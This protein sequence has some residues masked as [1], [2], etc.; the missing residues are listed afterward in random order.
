M[1]SVSP[2]SRSAS[3][4]PTQRIGIRP[5]S[6]AAGTFSA[7]ARSVSPK[8]SRRSECPSTTPWTSSSLSIGALTSPVN[9][10]SAAW[11]MFCAYTCTREPR[12]ES[13]IACRSVNGTQIATSTPS[14]DDTSG[15][16]PEMNISACDWVLNIFQLPAMNGVLAH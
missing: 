10:P 15:S 4:S 2:A 6:S 16:S 3:V 8:Y 14:E 1:R 13:T 9:A 11:C 12:V 5:A 7:S